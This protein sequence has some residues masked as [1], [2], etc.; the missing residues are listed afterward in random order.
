LPITCRSRL[1]ERL[2]SSG[3]PHDPNF[4]KHLADFSDRAAWRGAQA[5]DRS[6]IR[7]FGPGSKSI[8]YY[9][10]F[11]TLLFLTLGRADFTGLELGTVAVVSLLAMAVMTLLLVLIY[12]LGRLRGMLSDA[13]YTSVFQTSSRWNAFIALAIAHKTLRTRGPGPCGAG[14]GGDRHPAQSDQCRHAGLVQSPARAA[15]PTLVKRI[16]GN[17]LILGCACS[18]LPSILLPSASIRRSNRQ[19]T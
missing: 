17:P 2:T 5:R 8:G 10:L 14:D 1:R 19:S 4:R 3:G 18:E 13:S 16:V 15:C 7:A 12:P 11:P 9:V 6:S